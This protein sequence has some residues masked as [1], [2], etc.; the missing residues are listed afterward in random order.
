[1]LEHYNNQA[2]KR[3]NLG[4]P[5]IKLEKIQQP[6]RFSPELKDLKAEL[7]LEYNAA[8]EKLETKKT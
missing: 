5:A 4:K 1:M 8:L 7:Q 3:R 6:P 2:Q